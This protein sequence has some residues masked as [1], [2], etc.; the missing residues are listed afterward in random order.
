VR[1]AEVLRLTPNRWIHWS[2]FVFFSLIGAAGFITALH[3][4]LAGWAAFALS[5][6]LA[7]YAGLAAQPGLFY[8]ELTTDC[9]AEQTPFR[10]REWRW[11]DFDRFYSCQRGEERLVVFRYSGDYRGRS[12]SG[13]LG[14]HND[15]DG[16]L[17]HTGIPSEAQADLL[18]RWLERCVPDRGAKAPG[19]SG[20]STS[21]E[22]RAPFTCRNDDA[23]HGSTYDSVL[24][25]P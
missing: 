22:F 6:L 19:E 24:G 11:R 25:A 21:L 3:G 14:R 13:L 15:W 1:K 2:I 12:K 17:I 18:N 9:L 7:V 20:E 8:L 23:S 5:T 10:R 4:F 16:R